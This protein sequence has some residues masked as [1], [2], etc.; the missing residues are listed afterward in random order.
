MFVFQILVTATS[1]ACI[2][3]AEA[4]E[5]RSIGEWFSGFF[6]KFRKK[7]TPRRPSYPVLSY[8][9]P[10][11]DTPPAPH[12]AEPAHHHHQPAYHHRPNLA[13]KGQPVKGHAPKG[14]GH[15]VKGRPV[16]GHAVKGHGGYHA[17]PAHGHGHGHGGGGGGYAHGGGHGAGFGPVKEHDIISQGHG[18]GAA[19]YAPPQPQDSYGA[20]SFSHSS[21]ESFGHP[22]PHTIVAPGPAPINSYAPPVHTSSFALSSQ[23]YRAPESS[24]LPMAAHGSSATSHLDGGSGVQA[25]SYSY[26][27]PPPAPLYKPAPEQSGT[28]VPPA[29]YQ[30]PIPEGVPQ[31]ALSDTYQS[32]APAPAPAPIPVP[33]PAPAPVYTGPIDSAPAPAPIFETYATPSDDSGT[34]TASLGEDDPIIEIVF[35]DSAP[36]PAPPPPTFDPALF[37]PQE[38]EV[39]VY[40]IEY[41]PDTPIDN[42]EDL[43]LDGAQQAILEDLPDELPADIRN[44]LISSGMLDDA[45]IQVV[46]LQ[47]GDLTSLERNELNAIQQAYAAESKLVEVYKNAPKKD[48]NQAVDVRVHRVED[49]ASTPKGKVQLL[50]SFGDFREGQ[51]IGTVKVNDKN[52]E[53]FLPLK[54]DNQIYPLPDHPKLKDKPIKGVLVVAQSEEALDK[55]VLPSDATQVKY[56]QIPRSFSTT[57]DSDWIPIIKS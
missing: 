17:P 13:V 36:A 4:R 55:S 18:G 46:D 49:D 54:I 57:E 15:P 24:A 43:R 26:N 20:P 2:E 7:E 5:K 34:F 31:L 22:A 44:Q 50:N 9:V 33:V 28:Y 37:A 27:V 45:L 12:Y 25:P 56:N 16:K 35:E 32:P 48:F 42:I 3:L 14:H 40:F 11:Y 6:N 19:A 53:K 1:L 47:D 51:F 29:G 41:S 8:S 39:E 38:E 23:E 52:S 30:A 21:I 10:G